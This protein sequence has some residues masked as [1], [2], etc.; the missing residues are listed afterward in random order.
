M[1]RRQQPQPGS[2]NFVYDWLAGRRAAT[3]KMVAKGCGLSFNRAQ[4]CL[5]YG[6]ATGDI[7]RVRPAGNQVPWCWSVTRKEVA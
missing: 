7:T 1:T 2:Y 5:K 4:S 6:L 3:T